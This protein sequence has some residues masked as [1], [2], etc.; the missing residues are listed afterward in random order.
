ML[1]QVQGKIIVGGIVAKDVKTEPKTV[2]I[3]RHALFEIDTVDP[4]I[5]EFV[6]SI[7]KNCGISVL[8]HPCGSGYHYFGE[9]VAIELW[10][11]W[12]KAVKPLN[13]EWPPQ[14]LRVT[15]KWKDERWGETKFYQYGSSKAG[16]VKPLADFIE[17][18]IFIT[19]ERP[20]IE[21]LSKYWKYI[22]Y[23]VGEK[24]YD[25]C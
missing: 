2:A 8:V 4:K 25:V 7:Y 19:G 11:E 13:P 15:R 20:D 3:A 21:K 10:R 24:R 1:Y 9:V 5:H 17:K 6:L 16:W 14:T 22:E 12:Y 18:S 23:Y